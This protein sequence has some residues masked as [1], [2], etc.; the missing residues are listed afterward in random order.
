MLD[1]VLNFDGGG[2]SQ[3]GP[4][5]FG[6]VV[7]VLD[8]IVL[9]QFGGKV[10]NATVNEAEYAG[11]IAGL[12]CVA[13]HAPVASLLVRGDSQLVIYQMTGRY[14]CKQAHLKPLREEAVALCAEHG[15]VT[16]EWVRRDFNKAADALATE[17]LHSVGP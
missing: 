9:E 10:A 1:L 7:T 13:K 4:A 3:R 6:V 16:F 17:A 8:G 15:A 5:A 12:K 11:L 2:S 14:R